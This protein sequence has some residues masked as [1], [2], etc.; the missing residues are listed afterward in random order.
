[1]R[2]RQDL[3]APAFALFPVL[4]PQVC[5]TQNPGMDL[6]LELGWTSCVLQQLVEFF[7]G[8]TS[9]PVS[10]GKSQ[11][12]K[13]EQI[14]KTTCLEGQPRYCCPTVEPVLACLKKV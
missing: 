4:L 3:I 10:R 11:K 14:P 2:Q 12:S 13:N 6:E 7:L 8:V 5:T 9:Y 1:M